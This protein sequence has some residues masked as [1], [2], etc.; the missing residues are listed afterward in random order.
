MVDQYKKHFMLAY[1]ILQFGQWKYN[2]R[3]I[4]PKVYSEILGNP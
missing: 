1:Q 2:M 4:M 3:N